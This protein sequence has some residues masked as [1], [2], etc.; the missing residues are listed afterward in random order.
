ME[1]V[2]LDVSRLMGVRVCADAVEG[3][4]GREV[5]VRKLAGSAKLGLKEGSPTKFCR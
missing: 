3:S 5:D 1:K 2:E 4:A